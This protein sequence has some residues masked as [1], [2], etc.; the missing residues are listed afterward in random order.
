MSKRPAT[1]SDFIE[2][3]LLPGREEVTSLK[4][5]HMLI[6]KNIM[7]LKHILVTSGQGHLVAAS[8]SATGNLLADVLLCFVK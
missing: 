6:I 3:N 1:H 2:E 7:I 8:G 4:V 5:L